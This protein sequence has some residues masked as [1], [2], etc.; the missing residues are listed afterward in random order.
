M[1]IEVVHPRSH[2]FD[3]IR[4]KCYKL[5]EI[6]EKPGM[7]TPQERIPVFSGKGEDLY[8]W[9]SLVNGFIASYRAYGTG[10]F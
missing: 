2:C 9:G 6:P 10:S 3:H 8:D 1:T 7:T 4:G 5:S